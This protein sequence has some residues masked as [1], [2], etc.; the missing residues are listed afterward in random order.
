MLNGNILHFKERTTID[1]ANSKN[2]TKVV[3][4]R[5]FQWLITKSLSE[6]EDL[7]DGLF[8]KNYFDQSISLTPENRQSNQRLLLDVEKSGE[9]RR[10]EQRRLHEEG[11]TAAKKTVSDYM[12]KCMRRH[13]SDSVHINRKLI[14]LPSAF[15]DLM[16][17]LY[18]KNSNYKTLSSLIVSTTG[19]EKQL[20]SLVNNPEFCRSVGREARKVKTAQAAVGFIGP[21][22]LKQ[23]IPMMVIKSQL[24]SDCTHYPLMAQKLWSYA[25]TVANGATIVLKNSGY[26]GVNDDARELDGTFLGLF[27]VLGI[28]AIH[29]QFSLSFEDAKQHFLVK[30]RE[31]KDRKL[32]DA[33][34]TVEANLDLM[35]EFM[36]EFSNKI[37]IMIAE[38]FKWG[39]LK[40][41]HSALLKS[42][43][44]SDG[45]FDFTNMCVH[46]IALNQASCY[47]KFEMLRRAKRFTAK[48]HIRPYLDGTMLHPDT[49]NSLIKKDLRKMDLR[50]YL[51]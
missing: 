9:I 21:Q 27:S 50:I 8:N 42:L 44:S 37:T 47:A 49:I 48:E 20:I 31:D 41:L 32:Y 17:A 14:R 13:L 3:N 43:G 23:V 45:P 10:A 19:L 51:G 28:I 2:I 24:K 30:Y 29:H 35:H 36:A 12:S 1:L 25:I 7:S 38:D 39:G 34:L 15:A 33:M 4:L 26:G 22:G 5:H 40:Y 6:T 18:S 11:R 46:S 16:D